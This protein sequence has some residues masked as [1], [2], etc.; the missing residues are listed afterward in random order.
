MLTVL[1]QAFFFSTGVW[2]IVLLYMALLTL[3]LA[4]LGFVELRSHNRNLKAI[5]VRIHVNGTRGKSSVTR[6]IAAGLR[7]HGVK[8]FAKTTGTLP[9]VITDRGDEYPVHRPLNAN[10]IE[11]LRIVSFAARNSAEVLVIECMALQPNLQSL[12]ELKLIKSTHG[13]ITNARAD[14]L[15]VMGPDERDVALA[16][17]GS[18]PRKAKLFT[19]EKDYIEEFKDVCRDRDTEL[20]IV[21]D[22]EVEIITD[23]EMEEFSYVEHKENVAL[24]L[25]V[26]MDMAVPRNIA[27]AG[28]QRVKPDIGAMTEYQLS[29]FGRTIMFVN[30]FAAN[31]PESSEK[32][33]NIAIER[34]G[35]LKRR[36]MIINTRSDRP[37]RSQ[38]IGESIQTWEPA[39]RYIVI[40]TG[41]YVL[42][43]T[44]VNNG[45]SPSLFINLEGCFVDHIFETVVDTSGSSAMV[46]GIGNIKDVGLDLIKYF[47]NRSLL[48][49]QA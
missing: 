2:M 48:E 42:I 4:V 13:V 18:T 34:H 16:L 9:R 1:H 29:F 21:E 20:R 5:P 46:M 22:D 24:A 26:C 35:K 8:V 25:K 43:R 45:M 12:T 38:Q 36:I 39:D 40:G 30:G 6:L 7:A 32:I 31:D 23:T 37:D 28:M 27:L 11:Q 3:F 19:C 47:K 14:H 44:A 15:D 41:C 10:I 17:L 33:W 49:E